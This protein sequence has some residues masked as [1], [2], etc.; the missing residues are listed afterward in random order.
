MLACDSGFLFLFEFVQDPV[1]DRVT[2]TGHACIHDDQSECAEPEPGFASRF[3]AC[4]LE[5]DAQTQ[6]KQAQSGGGEDH[7][8]LLVGHARDFRAASRS[9]AIVPPR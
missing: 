7:P 6:S 5:R 2:K 3:G 4:R 1:F 9:G 8:F